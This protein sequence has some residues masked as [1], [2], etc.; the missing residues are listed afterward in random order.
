MN[1]SLSLWFFNVLS[2]RGGHPVAAA[3]ISG[4][5]HPVNLPR[6]AHSQ[7][8]EK[9]MGSSSGAQDAMQALNS[10]YLPIADGHLAV[11]P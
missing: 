7:R 1:R 3:L 10:L 9:P 8:C 11:T 5:H 4:S 2:R 6:G